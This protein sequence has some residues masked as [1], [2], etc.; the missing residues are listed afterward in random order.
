M[1][2][3]SLAKNYLFNILKTTMGILFPLITFPY[4]TR[5]LGAESLGKINY[6]TSIVSYFLLLSALGLQTYA[7]R[8]GAGYREDKEALNKF[9]TEM[10]L[11]NSLLTVAAYAA[12][13]VCLGLVPKFHEYRILLMISSVT[14]VFN[15][16]GFNWLYSVF[17]EYAYITVRAILFQIISLAALLLLVK[18]AED[19]YIYA[20]INV[21]ASA[22]SNICNF[23]RMRRYMKLFPG[24]HYE[25]RK[26]MKPIITIFGMSVAGT[27]Y[28]DSD[29]TII[30]Y[31]K[32]DLSVGLYS[33]A[34]KI[35]YVITNMISSLGAVILPRMSYYMKSGRKDQFDKLTGRTISF[36]LMLTFPIAMGLFLLSEEMLLLVCGAEFI[37]A[38]LALK[39]LAFNII[40]S[41]LNGV[42][43]NQLFI[44][45]G[46]EKT[47]LKVM[48]LSCLFNVFA[49]VLMIS[50]LG[51][52]AA[53]FTTICSEVI[54]LVLFVKYSYQEVPVVKYFSGTVQYMVA[55][56]VM[57]IAVAMIKMICS[58]W[59]VFISVPLGAFVY[60]AVLKLMKNELLEEGL[61]MIL[62]KGECN[63]RIEECNTCSDQ[64]HQSA[65]DKKGF[66]IQLPRNT[67]W[68]RSDAV[69]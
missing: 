31:M 46:K 23:I 3:K 8:E 55:T 56:I 40:L 47:S 32:G 58:N 4:A 25:L 5:V 45:L 44:T 7:I 28:Q 64:Q 53:A 15:T 54:V 61:Y 62:K 67:I 30:G 16:M 10:F 9:G 33:A 66:G 36:V 42:V 57:A 50:R 68:R 60:F 14:I 59:I 43:V 1:K 2:E 24:G 22:G 63:V 27:I 6:A 38:S 34:V 18:N 17:E 51:Y 48:I 37:G 26:H 11:I 35:M 13:F 29:I 21:F 20:T 19:Y 65:T 39:I 49:N 12:F 41:P 69:S 52:E